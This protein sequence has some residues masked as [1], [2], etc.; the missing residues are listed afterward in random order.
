[1]TSSKSPTSAGQSLTVP[2]RA[3]VGVATTSLY[4]GL[5][6]TESNLQLEA[7][8]RCPTRSQSAVRCITHLVSRWD[9]ASG[10]LDL[11]QGETPSFSGKASSP[12]HASNPLS[13]IRCPLHRR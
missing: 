6:K 13:Y 7:D 10:G 5:V 12:V 8:G 4:P 1:M 2:S 11:S 9:E 3:Q